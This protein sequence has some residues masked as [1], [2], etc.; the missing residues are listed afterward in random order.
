MS[1]PIQDG[2][3]LSWHKTLKQWY[4]TV[5]VDIDAKTGKAITKRKYFG[6]GKWKSDRK[7][8][9]AAVDKYLAYMREWDIRKAAQSIRT[10]LESGKTGSTKL[11]QWAQSHRPEAF[12]P[13]GDEQYQRQRS[14]QKQAREALLHRTSRGKHVDEGEPTISELFDRWLREEQTRVATKEITQAG[15]SSKQRGIKTFREYTQSKPFGSAGNVQKM[16]TGYRSWLTMKLT[17]GDYTGNTVND[18][19][20][21]ATQFIKWAYKNHELE[22]LP[23]G[24]DDFAKK[25]PV[26]KGGESLTVEQVRQIWNAAGDRMKCFIALGLNCGFKNVDVA[27][28]RASD[29]HNGRLISNRSKTKAP[30][31]YR[32]WPV[33][34]TLL[35]RCRE[36]DR[37]D[38]NARLF[39]AQNGGAITSGSLS[40]LFKKTATRA[41]VKLGT[42]KAGNTKYA[43]FEQLRDTSAELIRQSLLKQGADM[44]VVQLFLAHK[45]SSTAAYY[46]SNDPHTLKS[47]KLDK[48]L[49]LLD[50][51]YGLKAPAVTPK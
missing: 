46:V 20:K 18:K 50:K 13:A 15:V 44:A 49:A 1:R 8:Y 5:P 35:D 19:L 38:D 23:R 33:T 16:L 25:V 41:G 51:T 4:R 29:L 9:N 10:N 2:R 24:L 11:E 47:E 6:S 27:E 12:E 42:T 37:K 30:M 45:D 3:E 34:L 48:E 28:L 14:R 39:N 21:F 36:D 32:L 40:V 17:S 43:T 26:T 31:N 22:E 7:S